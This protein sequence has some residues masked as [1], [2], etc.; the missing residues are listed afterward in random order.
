MLTYFASSQPHP[1]RGRTVAVTSLF[2]LM[3]SG[4]FKRVDSAQFLSIKQIQNERLAE[5]R[6]FIFRKNTQQDESYIN[7]MSIVFAFCKF[8]IFPSPSKKLKC[9]H[10]IIFIFLAREGGCVEIARERGWKMNEQDTKVIDVANTGG[11]K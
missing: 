1:F 5:M 9:L 2:S 10:I 8:S 3:G 6:I 7:G 4:R 11:N